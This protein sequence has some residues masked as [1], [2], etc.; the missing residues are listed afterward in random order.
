MCMCVRYSFKRPKP[1]IQHAFDRSKLHSGVPTRRKTKCHSMAERGCSL[2]IVT[3][4]FYHGERIT[5]TEFQD[6]V[7]PT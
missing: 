6:Q 4:C 5:T 7:R 3:A 2:E 1:I